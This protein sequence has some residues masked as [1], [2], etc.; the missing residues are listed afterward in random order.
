MYTNIHCCCCERHLKCLGQLPN[1]TGCI[2]RYEYLEPAQ[3]LTYFCSLSIEPNYPHSPT[4]KSELPTLMDEYL[5]TG[6]ASERVERTEV[7]C[8]YVV[9]EG[10]QAETG[11]KKIIVPLELPTLVPTQ[12]ISYINSIS[13]CLLWKYLDIQ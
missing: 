6:K 10:R 7:Q 4:K 13:L 5:I 8:A 1:C 3:S 11:S 12:T 2:Q 9:V